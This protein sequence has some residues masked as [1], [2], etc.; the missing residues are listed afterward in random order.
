M[1]RFDQ[2]SHSFVI[3]LWQER[4]MRAETAVVWR[5]WIEHVQSG[6][7]HYFNDPQRLQAILS[8]YLAQLPQLASLLPTTTDD[9]KANDC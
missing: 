9:V 6:K 2:E 8:T 1:V 5:G 3:R 4:Q 7:R